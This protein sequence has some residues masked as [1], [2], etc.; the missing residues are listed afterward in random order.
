MG[1]KNIMPNDDI[2]SNKI[3]FLC[4]Q[5]PERSRFKFAMVI[6]GTGVD[7]KGQPEAKN[8]GAVAYK[9]E[10]FLPKCLQSQLEME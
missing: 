1:N 8:F 2:F 4:V 5:R 6:N 10:P 3:R 7:L 9:L